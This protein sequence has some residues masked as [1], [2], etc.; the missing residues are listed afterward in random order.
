MPAPSLSHSLG[1]T[2]PHNSANET[3]AGKD[4]K[5]GTLAVE[6]SVEVV[7]AKCYIK[8][9]ASASLTVK[10]EGDFGDILGNYTEDVIDTVQNITDVIIDEAGDVLKEFAADL[11]TG[12]VFDPDTDYE[13]PTFDVDFDI[14][15]PELPD[16][17][18]RFEFEDD[19]ELYMELA[20]RLEGAAT[21]T[22]NL[23]SSQSPIGI[24]VGS[25]ITVGVACVIDLILDAR[26]ALE[27]SSGFHLKL[28]KGV[29]FELNMFSP[30]VSDLAL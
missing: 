16:V 5:G 28:D 19:F 21:Y 2:D 15:L 1:A 4:G 29:G 18:V 25:D 30:N 24:A 12:K 14:D 11:F 10:G 22:L 3:Q 26:A 6:A 8:G 23:F 13:F 17:T 27:I 20:V 9:G 7:C